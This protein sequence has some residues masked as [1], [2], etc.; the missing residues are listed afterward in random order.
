MNYFRKY[1]GFLYVVGT[2]T[3]CGLSGSGCRTMG[4]IGSQKHPTLALEIESSWRLDSQSTRF[5]A[6]GIERGPNG[7]LLV[8]RDSE[9][10]VYVVKFRENSGVARLVRHA[11][12]AVDG[13]GRDVGVGR[14]DIEG[15]AVDEKGDVFLCD[16]YAR[17]VLRFTPRGDL[18]SIPLELTGAE[19][20][21]SSIDANASFEGIAIGNGNL[22]LANERNRGRLL[23]I[24]LETGRL[25]STFEARTGTSAWPDPHYS[26]LDFHNGRLFA[27][28]REEQ[29]I[30]EIDPQDKAVTRVMRYHDIEFDRRHRY[31]TL[32]PFAGI[33]EGVLIE[34]GV[35]W[36]L[37]DNNGEARVADDTDAR[38]TL[39]RCV[40]RMESQGSN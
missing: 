7:D 30:V 33:M 35:V 14:F 16:E 18:E 27:L 5:D 39:F 25:L 8:V 6:S 3:V 4:Q 23:E 24:D 32:V 11:R 38:P 1:D 37:T 29:A 9:L 13:S 36:L 21:F 26:G 34:N 12:Y 28:L 22:Y 15:L 17:R 40:V 2:L 10:A 20:F 19:E 31:K